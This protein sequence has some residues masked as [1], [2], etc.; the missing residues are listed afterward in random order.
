MIHVRTRNDERIHVIIILYFLMYS[1]DQNP[2][3]CCD[4][5]LWDSVVDNCVGMY[6][7]LTYPVHFYSFLIMVCLKDLLGTLRLNVYWTR[8]WSVFFFSECSPGYSGPGCIIACPYPLYGKNCQNKCTC[9]TTEYCNFMSGC[10]KGKYMK[11]NNT[12]QAQKNPNNT[13]YLLVSDL[14]L[15][16]ND[17]IYF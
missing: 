3:G 10:L 5:Y 1:T 17:F 12:F 15:N 8:N 4:G 2:H 9:S 16:P 14:K 7:V 13:W 6:S 11:W